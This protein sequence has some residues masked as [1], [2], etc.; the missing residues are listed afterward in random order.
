[1]SSDLIKQL[2]T[3]I[4]TDELTLPAL[5]EVA[6]RIRSLVNDPEISAK[7]VISAISGDVTISAHL[8][9]VA[10]SAAYSDKPKVESVAQAISRLGYMQVHNIVLQLTMSKLVQAQ[11]PV[12]NAYI[13][14]L[15]SRNRELAAVCHVLARTRTRL[16][17]DQAMFAGL[18]HEIGK[19]PLCQFI[20]RLHTPITLEQLDEVSNSLG[21]IAGT[22]LLRAWNFP[23]AMV[24]VVSA[25]TRGDAHEISYRD[26]VLAAKCLCDGQ[27]ECTNLENDALVLLN[28]TPDDRLGFESRHAGL[29]NHAKVLLGAEPDEEA[30][31]SSPIQVEV[32]PEPQNDE[33][34]Q[35]N[36]SPTQRPGL[37]TRLLKLLGLA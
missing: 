14:Q 33:P 19:L 5:P 17:P 12:I 8:V 35:R 27:T 26:L 37:L 10:N 4:E 25:R 36:A 24:Q 15:W 31:T 7:E 34:E 30:P 2:L 3:A 22:K 32:R 28:L 29:L 1:M 9:K 13:G 16:N 6:T 18:I 11:N 23:D 20:D 21:A